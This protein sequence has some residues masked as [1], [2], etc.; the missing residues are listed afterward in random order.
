MLALLGTKLRLEQSSY[1]RVIVE[2]QRIDVL[3]IRLTILQ[4]K[5]IHADRHKFLF[6]IL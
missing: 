5:G 3:M 4:P 2:P 1:E 6:V